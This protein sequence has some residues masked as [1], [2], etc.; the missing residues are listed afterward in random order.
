MQRGC[1]S[2][3]C[4]L[5][6]VTVW[7]RA[8]QPPLTITD[9]PP[10]PAGSRPTPSR[11]F[12]RSDPS[13]DSHLRCSQRSFLTKKSVIFKPRQTLCAEKFALN[14]GAAKK[15]GAHARRF[16]A[17]TGEQGSK[18]LMGFRGLREGVR[19]EIPK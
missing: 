2:S 11:R 12:T 14:F 10:R 16:H 15:C 18:G 7:I 19:G 8:L 6:A 1:R 9:A 4:C 13:P 17:S 5:Q 3:P